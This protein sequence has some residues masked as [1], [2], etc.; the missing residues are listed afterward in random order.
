MARKIPKYLQGGHRWSCVVEVC[1]EDKYTGHVRWNYDEVVVKTNFDADLIPRLEMALAVPYK[2][3]LVDYD[4]RVAE[5][6][7][8]EGIAGHSTDLGGEGST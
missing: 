1:R 5:V 6:T 2:G 8:P 3:K 4:L 7:F